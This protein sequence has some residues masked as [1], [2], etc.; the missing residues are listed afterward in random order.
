MQKK[1]LQL[2]A[3]NFAAIQLN[4][5]LQFFAESSVLYEI[6]TFRFAGTVLMPDV[7]WHY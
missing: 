5:K 2:N 6:R 4:C 3:V 7:E 1:A